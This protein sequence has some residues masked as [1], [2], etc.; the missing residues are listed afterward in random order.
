MPEVQ[1]RD[2]EIQGVQIRALRRFSDA[3]GWLVELFRHDELVPELYPV[4]AYVSE[5][6]PGVVRGPHE[7]RDQTDYFAFIGPGDFKLYLW[8][9]RRNSPTY[10][11]AQKLIVGE[12]NAVCVTIPPGV[13]HAYKNISDKPGLVFNAPNRLYG[14]WGKKEKVDEIRYEDLPDSPFA[15]D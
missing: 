13:V 1:F 4:M 15:I 12:S 14:G 8:D 6:L 5:T 10:L 2:G 11:V 7:H 3:R 9:Y